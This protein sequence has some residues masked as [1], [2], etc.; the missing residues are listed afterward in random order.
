MRVRHNGKGSYDQILG[1]I[2][3]HAEHHNQYE[4]VLAVRFN[5][6]DFNA[7]YVPE[8]Y[9]MSKSLGI[10]YTQFDI[11]NTVNYDY[12]VLIPT[13]NGEQFKRLY[14]DLVKLKIEHGE[15]VTDFPRPTFS[16]CSAYTPTTS[17]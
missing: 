12:N 14:L 5:V 9:H 11:F 7:K 13:L 1:R 16:P 15:I 8:V 2:Q 3:R 17:R 4:T 10:R 6:N